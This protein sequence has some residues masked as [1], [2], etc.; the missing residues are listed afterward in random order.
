[1]NN[2]ISDTGSDGPLVYVCQMNERNLF[3]FCISFQFTAMIRL[4]ELMPKKEKMN[5]MDKLIDDLDLRGCLD[6]SKFFISNFIDLTYK[7]GLGKMNMRLRVKM[8]GRY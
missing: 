5:R 3:H 7:K 2:I 6:T 4:P 1:M 8:K